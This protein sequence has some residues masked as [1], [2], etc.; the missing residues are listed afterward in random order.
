K[1]EASHISWDD[2][3]LGAE[4]N[5]KAAW[6]WHAEN[7]TA[8]WSVVLED[9]ALPVDGFLNQAAAALTEAPTQ[10]VSFYLGQA[11]PPQWQTKIA[12]AIAKA[13][14][15]EAHWI[16]STALIHG[17][18]VALKTDLIPSMLNW[19]SQTPL[20][21]DEAVS[22]WARAHHKAVAYTLPSLCDHADQGT[23]I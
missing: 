21:I 2:G 13:D 3:T 17:V 18:A 7:N 1:V 9:D 8:P 4:G 6:E 15:N 14:A 19:V 12:D 16:V 11:R 20:P 5:H 22:H 23:L 10:L